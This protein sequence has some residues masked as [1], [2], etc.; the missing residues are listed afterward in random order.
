MIKQPA[1]NVV[2]LNLHNK[3]MHKHYKLALQYAE[4]MNKYE[5]P[6]TK[7][8]F[9]R[10]HSREWRNAT[11]C[12]KWHNVIE[13]RRIP[14]TI[15]VN[16]IEVPEPLSVVKEGVIMYVACPCN[17]NY[18]YEHTIQSAVPYSKRLLERKLLHESKENAVAHAKAMLQNQ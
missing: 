4:D 18:Y 12:P 2:A 15:T 5:K 8:Q 11:K 13:Y 6:W 17:T 16:G 14:D 9:Q 7:W 1:D 3:T 10:E